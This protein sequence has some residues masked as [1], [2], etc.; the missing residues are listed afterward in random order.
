MTTQAGW[1]FGFLIELAAAPVRDG[2]V[3]LLALV[4]RRDRN[5]TES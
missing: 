5:Q 4:S 2:I 1:S 3:H